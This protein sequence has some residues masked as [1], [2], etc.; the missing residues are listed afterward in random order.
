MSPKVSLYSDVNYT[1]AMW[2]IHPVWSVAL[3]AL[4]YVGPA[5]AFAL[6]PVSPLLALLVF[7]ATT[8][9]VKDNDAEAAELVV[10]GFVCLIIGY[11]LFCAGEYLLA[12]CT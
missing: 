8:Y 5:L 4:T 10:A 3:T 11:A 1:A 2:Y 12:L 9:M 7:L 6:L